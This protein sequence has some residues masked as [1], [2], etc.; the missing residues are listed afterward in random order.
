MLNS[1]VSTRKYQENHWVCRHHYMEHEYNSCGNTEAEARARML[2]H[3][4]KNDL[5]EVP[6]EKE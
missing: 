4:I 1:W 5:I 2:I 3:L 6:N